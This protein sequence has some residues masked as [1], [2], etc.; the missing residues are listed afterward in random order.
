LLASA[1]PVP[2]Q[3]ISDANDES[4]LKMIIIYGRHS[5]RACT[6]E[7]AQ[8]ADYATD[9]YPGF[10]VAAGEL[11]PRGWQ[12]EFLLGSY[13]HDY[14]LHEGLVT[15]DAQEDAARSYFRAQPIARTNATAAAFQAGVIPAV[16][17]PM[18]H[19]FP[20]SP[21]PT[22]P[23]FD[24]IFGKVVVVDAARA[25][26]EVQGIY[27]NGDALRSAC[28]GEYSL[29]RSV[30]FDYPLGTQPPPATPEGKTDVTAA[31]ITLAASA[32]VYTGN[33]IDVGGLSNAVDACDSFIM[34]YADGFPLDQVAWGRLTPDTLS[35]QTRILNLEFRIELLSPYL[36]QVQSSN[37]ASHV[38]R[39]LKRG[40]SGG[41]VRGAFGSAKTRLH[42]IISSDGYIAGLAGLLGL[43]WQLP[44][45]QP[46]FCS[47]G[48]AI[49]FELRQAKASREHFVRVFYTAQTLDQLRN[50]TPLTLENP[51][52]TMQLLVPG[53]SKSSTDLDVKFSVFQK[54]LKRAIE[55]KY[56]QNRYREIN[57]GILALADS[58]LK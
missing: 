4:T 23:V 20:I 30:L 5:I 22:D 19:S 10:D 26:A 1:V 38:L 57:P 16:A 33:V 46:D 17:E 29:I 3:T 51:P 54:I 7:P 49:V 12:A 15:D 58:P 34:Q 24:P 25:V 40:V 41:N 39:T 28:S 50:L 55:P 36:N 31:E 14:L 13:F 6:K 44:G 48:G 53:G 47:P 2:A 32:T 11:T 18:I 9:P 42:V 56:V 35:Q 52:A 45:Y 21:Y 27:N 37:L 8:L 43:H